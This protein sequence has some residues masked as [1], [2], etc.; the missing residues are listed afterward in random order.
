M[1][2]LIFCSLFVGL[3]LLMMGCERQS[4][5]EAM[6]IVCDPRPF[7]DE[8]PDEPHQIASRSAQIIEK[9][10]T[11]PEVLELLEVG[12]TMDYVERNEL[13]HEAVNRAGLESCP[14][15]GD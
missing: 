15:L 4:F 7:M 14:M 11:N 2:P 3:V 5:G 6:E 10:V 13:I 8:I 12:S 1:R 9:E